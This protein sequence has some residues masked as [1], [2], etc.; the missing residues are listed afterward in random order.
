MSDLFMSICF[1]QLCST[2]ALRVGSR[3]VRPFQNL[4]ISRFKKKKKIDR[5]FLCATSL[6]TFTDMNAICPKASRGN[7]HFL[8]KISFLTSALKILRQINKE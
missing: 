6:P 2:L 5:A 1:A 7:V 4:N 3:T 8:V